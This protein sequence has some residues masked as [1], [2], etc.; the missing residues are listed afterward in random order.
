MQ[1]SF[2]QYIRLKITESDF[3]RHRFVG[4]GDVGLDTYQALSPERR[5][6]VV[7]QRLTAGDF[8]IEIDEGHLLQ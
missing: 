4:E 3:D 2:L 6:A 1:G 8:L 7:H 5:G